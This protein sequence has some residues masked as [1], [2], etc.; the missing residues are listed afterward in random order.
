MSR[1]RRASMSM[2][3]GS[4][5][6]AGWA[7]PGVA[8]DR[9]QSDLRTH[10]VGSMSTNARRRVGW[11]VRGRVR[12]TSHRATGRGVGGAGRRPAGRHPLMETSA[13]TDE[14][15]PRW[16]R[17]AAPDGST[18]SGPPRQRRSTSECRYVSGRNVSGPQRKRVTTSAGRNV[19]GPQRQ[20]S[21]RQRGATST[22]RNVRVVTPAA[23]TSAG[24]NVSEAQRQSAVT[25]LR[26]RRRRT[27]L[28]SLNDGTRQTVQNTYKYLCLGVPLF[29]VSLYFWSPVTTGLLALRVTLD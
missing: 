17:A 16:P 26:C 29:R 9:I 13:D 19:S 5:W 14:G 18:V 15:G 4:Q 23:A 2:L 1:N 22:S 6:A 27:R 8:A 24:R 28:F 11:R 12:R 3:A 10:S 20:R 21:Q 25:C 7:Q